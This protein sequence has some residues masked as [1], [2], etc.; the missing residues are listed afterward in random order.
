[1]HVGSQSV[2]YEMIVEI[3]VRER[4]REWQNAWKLM[5]FVWRF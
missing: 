3:N 1:M 5:L 4:W 2:I